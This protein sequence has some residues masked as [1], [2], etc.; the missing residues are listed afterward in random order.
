M[1]TQGN[2][3]GGESGIQSKRL[4]KIVTKMS[5]G[6][7]GSQQD[8]DQNKSPN[9]S[10]ST[11][12]CGSGSPTSSSSQTRASLLS[13]SQ[14]ETF[15]LFDN[16]EE[17][18]NIDSAI[19]NVPL[20]QFSSS[21][22]T[23]TRNP[24]KSISLGGSGSPSSTLQASA[25][26][27]NQVESAVS[28]LPYIDDTDVPLKRTSR[29][30]KTSSQTSSSTV[31]QNEH[32]QAMKVANLLKAAEDS[33]KPST[34]YIAMQNVNNLVWNRMRGKTKR[35]KQ[36]QSS[37]GGAGKSSKRLKTTA[38]LLE[39]VNLAAKSSVQSSESDSDN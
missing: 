34:P 36:S 4:K 33:L 2:D 19:L 13:K 3:K 17:D 26:L 37:G 25:S 10:K 32:V 1:K 16:Y 22:T 7:I 9:S 20:E 5:S 35:I 8:K 27:F 39:Q 21:S 38:S 6:G 14:N 28:T 30:A 24:S 31:S 18:G 29:Y 12:A 15:Q 23:R 11:R